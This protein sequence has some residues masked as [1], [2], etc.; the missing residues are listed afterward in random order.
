MTDPAH[1]G[2]WY[3]VAQAQS[4][5]RALRAALQAWTIQPRALRRGRE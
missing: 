1:R 3:R 2:P 4:A 5:H